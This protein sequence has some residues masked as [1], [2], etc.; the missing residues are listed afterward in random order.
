V[1][2]KHKL[3]AVKAIYPIDNHHVAAFTRGTILIYNSD[4]SVLQKVVEVS[5]NDTIY[6]VDCLREEEKVYFAFLTK[7][8]DSHT[9]VMFEFSFKE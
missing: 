4:F 9:V 5:N 2:I 6:S 8:K 3:S 7:N 1:D